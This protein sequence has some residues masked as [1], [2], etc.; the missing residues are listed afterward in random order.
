MP[1]VCSRERERERGREREREREGDSADI[2]RRQESG[3]S[4]QAEKME[5]QP[6]SSGD[7][8]VAHQSKLRKWRSQADVP[9]VSRV[10]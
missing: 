2:F 4:I 7:K 3:A 1:R 8:R 5:I 6:T 9:S 10:F